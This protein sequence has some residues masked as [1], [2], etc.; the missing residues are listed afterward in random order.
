M[1]KREERASIIA[2]VKQEPLLSPNQHKR[3][4]SAG[5]EDKDGTSKKPI[6]LE[7]EK[8]ASPKQPVNIY[9][10]YDDQMTEEE[11]ELKK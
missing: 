8:K 11:L 5:Y 6:E 1:R 4:K 2:K 7:E 10:T 3:S 9:Q